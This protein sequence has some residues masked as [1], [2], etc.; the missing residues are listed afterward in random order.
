VGVSLFATFPSAVIAR[1]RGLII[2][3]TEERSTRSVR[4]D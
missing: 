3:L 1:L 2:V 4:D